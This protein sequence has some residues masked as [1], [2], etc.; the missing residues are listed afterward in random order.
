MA[1][2]R[3][4]PRNST[5]DVFDDEYAVDDH[6]DGIADG[7]APGRVQPA[8]DR[9]SIHSEDPSV[10][11]LHAHMADAP[12]FSTG[13][14]RNSMHKPR[15]VQNPFSSNED[16][17]DDNTDEHS[18]L[19]RS[20]SIQSSSTAQY[21]PGIAHRLS[22]ASSARGFPRT[23]SPVHGT[24]G[25]S[26]PYSMYPQ[27]TN[28]A[29]NPS[30]STTTSTVRAAQSAAVPNQGPAHP[31]SM[32]PQNVSDHDV[33]DSTTAPNHAPAII[34]VGFP[35]RTQNFVRTRGPGD[36]EQDIIGVD[37]HSEQLPPYSEYPEDGVPKPIVLPAAVQTATPPSSTH[38]L[39]PLMQQQ[40]Q[41]ESMSD[42]AA[43]HG[44]AE[45]QQLNSTDSY[46]TPSENKS[47][48][49][50]TWKEK[51]KTR[52]CGIPFWWIL[53]SLCVLA[54]IA[55]VLGAAI[56]GIFAGARKEAVKAVTK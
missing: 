30:T 27:D 21:A 29:R 52:F 8:N 55:I 51:R 33:A 32:Y 39:M 42:Q 5:D 50:K 37:G 10:R 19:H 13:S 6:Y 49:E 38:V 47:W 25:P 44:F 23:A 34:P 26:H 48:K 24:T 28:V 12:R 54:F 22:T 40:R 56:G 7:F 46:S 18:A 2:P 35:G 53:L 31:Y 17:D 15:H 3:N 11:S 20:S 16:D 45:M 43:A 9:W 1:D 41:P 4:H 36:E 14:S